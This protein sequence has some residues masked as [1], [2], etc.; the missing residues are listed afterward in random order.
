M[1]LACLKTIAQSDCNVLQWQREAL[2]SSPSTHINAANTSLTLGSKL[3][4]KNGIFWK[5]MG[6]I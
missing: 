2:G 6:Q 1:M 5:E 4:G 3:K